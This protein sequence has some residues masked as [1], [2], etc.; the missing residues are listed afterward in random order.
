MRII[1]GCDRKFIVHFFAQGSGVLNWAIW[2]VVAACIDFSRY[3]D[4][5]G[6]FVCKDVSILHFAGEHPTGDEHDGQ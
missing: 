2:D 5:S 3:T 6:R 4:N 1:V